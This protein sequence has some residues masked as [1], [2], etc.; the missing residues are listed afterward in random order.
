[1][2]LEKDINDKELIDCEL[3]DREMKIRKEIDYVLTKSITIPAANMDKFEK[4][5][6]KKSNPKI[7]GMID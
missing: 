5:G 2:E 7:I 3:K 1:M 6:I 4:E